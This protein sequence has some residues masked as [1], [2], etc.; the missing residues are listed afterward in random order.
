[1]NTNDLNQNWV[2]NMKCTAETFKHLAR[3]PKMNNRI[4][5]EFRA[6][7]EAYHLSQS[8]SKDEYSG[9]DFVERPEAL[10]EARSTRKMAKNALK[11]HGMKRRLLRLFE[12]KQKLHKEQKPFLCS[13]A[14]LDDQV[15]RVKNRVRDIDFQL[16]LI[17]T[18]EAEVNKALDG[19]RTCNCYWCGKKAEYRVKLE[20]VKGVDRAYFDEMFN[21]INAPCVRT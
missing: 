9:L 1:M 6:L 19:N 21:K 15:H 10:R 12:R 5:P 2:N 16:G 20:S 3:K 7:R 4:S 11:E 14:K 18:E 13:L 8:H 17:R